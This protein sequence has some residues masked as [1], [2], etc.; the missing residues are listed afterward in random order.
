MWGHGAWGYFVWGEAFELEGRNI[1]DDKAFKEYLKKVDDNVSNQLST[2]KP[3]A[4][5]EIILSYRAQ[6]GL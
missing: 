1:V 5:V 6:V 4:E 2:S 3:T